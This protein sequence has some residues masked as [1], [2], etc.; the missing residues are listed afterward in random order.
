MLLARLAYTIQHE[1]P[2]NNHSQ[3]LATLSFQDFWSTKDSQA[4][5]LKACNYFHMAWGTTVIKKFPFHLTSFFTQ[6]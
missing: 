1:F 6:Q 2:T 5:G 3:P 4:Q